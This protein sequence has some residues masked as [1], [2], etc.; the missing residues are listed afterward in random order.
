MKS[1]F[2]VAA[3]R[4][5]IRILFLLMPALSFAQQYRFEAF[6]VEEG[7][8][9]SQIAK[10][11]QD[12]QGYLWLGT[13]GG[14]V[15]RYN[16]LTFTNYSTKEGLV[17][18]IV[19]D[20]LEDH[21]GNLWFAT[22]GGVC[23]Y[24]GSAFVRLTDSQFLDNQPVLA[25]LEDRQRHLWLG[26]RDHGVVEFDGSEFS[27]YT[28]EQ[29]LCNNTVCGILQDR[30]GYLW[31]GTEGGISKFDGSTFVNFTEVAG[32]VKP[33]VWSM[34]EDRKGTLWFG[35]EGDG[36]L[37]Y[38][39]HAFRRYTTEDGLGA[40]N[41]RAIA[42]D[43][44]GNLWF[45]T[46]H[47]VNRFDG[48]DFTAFTSA[49]GLS[50]DQIRSIIEDREGNLWFGTWG[51]GLDKF[52]GSIFAHFSTRQGLSSNLVM[53]ILGDRSG[54]LWF[55]TWG[56]GVNKYEHGKFTPITTRE[57]LADNGVF[58]ILQDRKGNVWFGTA[59]GLSRF[60]GVRL[61]NFTTEN[62]LANNLVNIIFEDH[63]GN[64]WIGTR[65]GGVS[66]FDGTTFTNFTSK[67]GLASDNVF[68]I[69]EDQQGNLWFGTWGGG[70]CKYDGVKFIAVPTQVDLKSNVVL[71]ILQDTAGDLWLGT[72]G[73]G[74]LKYKVDRNGHLSEFDSFTT[75]DGLSDD[76]VLF[77]IFDDEENLWIGTNKGLSRLDCR[78]Y[79]ETGRK[80]FK[81]YGKEKGFIGIECNRNAAFRDKNGCLWFGTIE[82]AMRYNPA[83][84]KPNTVEPLT[85]ITNLRL[86]F[87]PVDWTKYTGKKL[88]QGHLPAALRLPY[89]KNHV[90]FD[91]IG[92]SL[93]IPAKVT[94]RYLLEGFDADWTPI[95]KQTSA[96]YSNLPPGDYTFKVKAANDDGVW[97]SEPATYHFTITPPFWR[98]WWFYLLAVVLSS[99][100]VLFIVRVRTK[101]LEAQRVRL[102]QEVNNRTS[103]LKRAKE[104]VERINAELEKLS[105][106]ASGTDNGVIIA[107]ATGKIEWVNAGFTRMNGYT[108]EALKRFKGETLIQISANPEIAE[109][110]EASIRNRASV[111]YESINETREGKRFWVSSTL[112]PIFDEHGQLKKLV[113]IDTDITE[114][115]E[116]ERALRE[117]EQKYRAL[118]DQIANPIFIFD[119]TSH[120]FLD[121]NKAV[122]R[123]YG[124]TREELQTMTPIDLHPEDELEKVQRTM[125]VKNVDVPITYTHVTKAGKRIAV[126]ILSDEIQYQGQPAWISIVRDVSERK[127]AEAEMQKAKETAEE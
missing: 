20:I 48:S 69:F 4:G 125:D 87:E 92:I 95:T 110:I 85:H 101:S 37:E 116:T 46:D 14:G 86:F 55:G 60:D 126:E 27:T 34:L 112:T 74:V 78:E 62:G 91:F 117:S 97:N 3:M 65:G 47:G 54:V 88:L 52:A 23:K 57:G 106:V 28:T 36:L 72:Y 10:I 58:S 26:T 50:N 64:L 94:Y 75:D 38:D 67:D 31:I 73:K 30:E 16:G 63:Q 111:I 49:Q 81:H 12:S 105:L 24:D 118:F 45:G 119:K 66:K 68:S 5:L 56:G 82:G 99:G 7:L 127:R 29:G 51:G 108:L 21:Q 120:H 124:Y 89:D 98:T 25:L 2:E 61:V 70:I 22:E 122:L 115:K 79:T 114:R 33:S 41:V 83:S 100:G 93:T 76:A 42:Q 123:I 107:D 18:N 40:N 80:V 6:S 71:A 32:T 102:E 121:C 8:A 104:K 59:K 109:N 84:D 96:T 43:G 113:V 103:E 53:S 1:S 11:F 15:S 9:Q 35:T 13:Y 17:N 77:M 44:Q 19:Y 90:T 39:R